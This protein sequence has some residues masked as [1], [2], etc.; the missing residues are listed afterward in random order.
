MERFP[1]IRTQL[2]MSTNDQYRHS[3][4]S[5]QQGD[6]R[7]T[8]FSLYLHKDETQKWRWYFYTPSGM[9]FVSSGSFASEREAREAMSEYEN[10]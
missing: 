4:A 1:S 5:L 7:M 6:M 3:L 9:C 2:S 10:E 8:N